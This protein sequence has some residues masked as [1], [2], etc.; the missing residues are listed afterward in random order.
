[1]DGRSVRTLD[2]GWFGLSAGLLPCPAAFAVLLVCLQL[3]ELTLG[4][5]MVAA[6]SA[7]L[8]VSLVAVGLAAAWS[9]R[10]ASARFSS[11]DRWARWMPY[12]SAGILA[13]VGLAICG[14]G[15]TALATA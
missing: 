8:A 12:A 2:I 10:L 5:S 15:V 13:A 3:R 1:L 7:G 6:F 11:F 9:G 4:I 14:R